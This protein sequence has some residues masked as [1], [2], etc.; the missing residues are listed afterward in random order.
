MV[1]NG[2]F[3]LTNP[4]KSIWNVEKYLEGTSINNICTV[5]IIREKID[6]SLMKRALNNIV[7]KNDAFR[8][9]IKLKDG[10][11]VQFFK[12]FEPFD[13]DVIHIKDES[14]LKD[15][16]KET[17]KYKFSVINSRLFYFKI[18]IFK[19]GQ[20][21]V[22][23]TV[24]HIISDSWSLGLVIKNILSE[25]H[26]V[27]ESIE[28]PTNY[29][30]I[31]YIKKE[32]EYKR[33]NRYQNDFDYWKKTFENIPEKAILPYD[34][35]G[36]KDKSYVAERKSFLI[37]KIEM[38]KIK[39]FCGKNKI[40]V[41][42]F[43][44]SVYAIYLGRVSGK[45]DFVIGTPILNRTSIKEKQTMGMFV[46]TTPIRVKIP[47]NKTTFTD[48][49]QNFSVKMITNL[50]HQRYSYMQILE[51]LHNENK[52]S[53]NLYSLL[54]S[55][56][57]TKAFDEKYGNYST[58]WVFNG[59][60]IDDCSIHLTDINN[61]GELEID[62][63]YLI[64]KYSEKEIEKT[65]NRILTII[66]Q[67]IKNPQIELLNIEI[68]TKEEKEKILYKF[69][70]KE[71]EFKNK[72]TLLEM[73]NNNVKKK[74]KEIAVVFEKQELTYKELDEK[75][76]SLADYLIKH[77]VKAEDVIS[78]VLK[79]S[80]DLIITIYA[81]IKTGA[82]YTLIDNS[83]PQ[84][85]INYIINDSKS[86]Y[87]I[88][89]N[90]K[91]II[92]CENIIN[93]KEIDI[94]RSTFVKPR[95]NPNLCIIYTSGSTGNPKGV[96]LEKAGFKNLLLAFDKEMNI[97]KYKNILGIATVSF[98]MFEVEL[99]SSLTFGNTLILANE[100][101]Q[102]NPIKMSKLIEKHNV[103]FLVT[104]PSRIELLLADNCKKALQI[105]KAFQLGGEKIT[106]NLYEKL[107]KETNAK[108]F[109]GYGPTEITACC[110]NK[111]IKEKDITIG[112]PIS[113]MQ[114]YICN[115][116]LMLQPT[117][118]LGEICIAGIGVSKGYINNKKL[119]E[120]KFV[121][122]PF[123]EG[124][125][126]KTGDLGLY[127]DNGDIEY[128]GRI[129]NQVKIRGLRIELE[130]IEDKINKIPHINSNVVL[131]MT[132]AQGHDYLCDYFTAD[133]EIETQ[134]IRNQLSQ[135]LPTYM[136]PRITIQI[137]KMP[138]TI[139]GK[140]DK[141]KLKGIK[142]DFKNKNIHSSRN[143]TDE[144]LL[145]NLKELL[146]NPDIGIDDSFFE[147][148]GDSLVA[149]NLIIRIQEQLNIQINVKDIDENPVI[150]DLSDF[151]AKEGTVAE[152]NKIIKVEKREYYRTSTAQKRIYF[153][154]K[155]AGEKNIIYNTPGGII[156]NGKL[157]SKKLEECI[158]IIIDRHESL[159]TYFEIENGEV[160]QKIIEKP[161]FKLKIVKKANYE[162]IPQIFKNFVSYFDLAKA[163][164]FKAMYIE[165]TNEKSA[166]FIDAHH[167]IIDGASLAILT[168]EICKIYN[169]EKLEQ[170]DY[171]YKDFT[172]YEAEKIASGKFEEAEKYW[173]EQ[174][175]GEIP[176]LNMPTTYSRPVN[177]SFEGKKVYS[178]IN[179]SLKEKI[180]RITKNTGITQY[181]LMLT[182][183]Y[184]LLSRYTAQEDIV[185][186][187]PIV[188]RDLPET[189][190][191]IGMFVN[192]LALRMKIDSENTV[193]E[194][195]MKVKEK[196][197][198][199]YE[200]QTYPFDELVNK[201]DLSRDAT[202]NPLISTMFTY[203]NN[204]Y[205]SLKFKDIE[206]KY[207]VPDINI[208]KFDLSLEVIPKKEELDISLEYATKLFEEKFITN[209]V[210]NYLSLLEE[211]SNNIDAKISKL[212]IVSAEEE[213]RLK[214]F[215]N[216]Y[217]EYPK[218]KSL[219]ELFEQ[220]VQKTPDN[221]AVEFEDEY[222][223][224][225]QLDEKATNL[226][227]NIKEKYNI[228][229]ND[230][231]GIMTSRSLEMIVAIIAVLKTGG[232][233]IPIDP[234]YP[235]DRIYYMLNSSKAK[236][237]L[238]Q[239]NLETKMEYRNKVYV[240]LKDNNLYQKPKEE[241]ELKSSPENLAYVIF[242]SGSTGN[243]KGV[244]LKQSNII[245]FINGMMKEFKFRVEDTIVSVTTIS[246]DI[247]VLE[248]LMPLLNGMKVIIANE[249]QQINGK[250][251]NELC[252]KKDVN[253]IQTTP[254]RLQIYL[255]DLE[256]YDFLENASHILIGGEPFPQNLLNELKKHTK[257][258][259]YNMYGPTET[260]VW[261]TMKDLS[262]TNK[263]TIGKPIINTQVYILD[264]NL[265]TQPI[266]VPGEI[267]IA[268]DG[269]SEGYLDNIEKT[270]ESFINNP[271]KNQTI[272]YKTGDIG[273][274]TQNGEIICFGRIDNQVKIR[275]LRIELEEIETV[276]QNHPSIIK[277]CVR[278]QTIDNR[279]FLIAYF[280][281]KKKV[282]NNEI[283]RYIS[284]YLPRYMVP[285]YY[286]P[287][288]KFPYTPNGKIDKKA[289][290]M[291]SEILQT[292]REKYV[293]PVTELEKK[294]VEIWEK[295]LNI[296]PIG[297]EDNFFELGGD[298]LLAMNLNLELL[299][300][301][302]QV[303]Y[304]D[305][306]RYPTIIEQEERINAITKELLF[307][308]IED[309]PDEH[310]NTL[311]NAK[312]NIKIEKYNPR[313]V[314]ITGATGFLGIHILR[315]FITNGNCN[316]YCI[317][318]DSQGI[319]AETR[320]YQKLHYYFGNKYDYLVGKRIIGVT[321]DASKP[322]FGLNEEK[323]KELLQKIDLVINSAA[324]VAH[325]GNYQKFYNTNVK[326]VKFITEFCKKG[327]IKLYHISTM[328][329]MGFNLDFSYMKVNNR[330]W[331]LK[332]KN[333]VIFDESKLYIGQLI[334][335]V[336]ARSKFEAE[337]HVLNEINNGL[338]AYILRMG[339]L[340]PRFSDGVF[341]ENFEE[342]DL[343]SKLST[344]IKLGIIPRYLLDH[345]IELTPVDY[346]AK[347]IY[348][349]TTNCNGT[350]RI[351]HLYNHNTISVRKLV[352]F[353]NQMNKNIKV[354][355]EKEFK[356]KIKELIN[357]KESKYSLKKLI[358][359]FDNN[360]HLKYNND[361]ITTS[362]FTKK[363]LSRIGFKWCKLSKSY[364]KKMLELLE[365]GFE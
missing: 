43:F 170:L 91:D 115:E 233:Y 312:Q 70:K 79:R 54:I 293:A 28:L 269:V 143:K 283:R 321:G 27:K 132:D 193:R 273:K 72:E 155:K 226:A 240:D 57:V 46:N 265:N 64:E 345:H 125:L 224:Y 187:S 262:D 15:V 63:D 127:R 100:E 164:I 169:D 20:G 204:G 298:S 81:I 211:I 309:L 47:Q 363:Y 150:K 16:E 260:A 180:E 347:A 185:I 67:I 212:K 159:R 319:K 350:N 191:L 76:N 8:I 279:E 107:R 207:Y 362:K 189:S 2:C 85:R 104:T 220:Q 103:E 341:Q 217:E 178:T 156:I 75:S 292:N 244:M 66:E 324:N 222:L 306:F 274:Y 80:L 163:P 219:A 280:K 248:S 360:L 227:K 245:N 365:E 77:G 305:I 327:K 137:E 317:I 294:L 201:L 215:N 199:A 349:L 304:Q 59:Y 106:E 236:L 247:F 130:E 208:S 300:L 218:N 102:K 88:V 267:Y 223:T 237:L 278:K 90:P 230:L 302:G 331:F 95:K 29:S 177:Q 136:I 209:L 336:Y 308:K 23:L 253:I 259:I 176:V 364:L 83:F 56:Q 313:N 147:I 42:N 342:N 3:E 289:L 333:K 297:I 241:I 202:R 314:L 234:N 160:V 272:M 158:K 250:A 34:K 10:K 38:E 310:I 36:N 61:T 357:D 229:P 44:M 1:E 142:V 168:E 344:F 126:Y 98:D 121:K 318:R 271:F 97:S 307:K 214:K 340:M 94:K 133:K 154:S 181:M 78:V 86:K 109:N 172:E 31:D 263:I 195:T 303:S 105:L 210:K 22:F 5:G 173:L 93:I 87:C 356:E 116:D 26:A 129:D 348:K 58:K 6:E 275:G 140:I 257:G 287:L 13:I 19:N 188:G 246:F 353:A 232:A 117:G 53:G 37:N 111:L 251:F 112:T 118:I 60:N 96:L 258:R 322:N 254:S 167:I 194:L 14:E 62:Y 45:D 261:S 157:D 328:S 266:G 235:S 213:K 337:S 335:N 82:T 268:G 277:A 242:T 151:I 256:N 249:E 359:D 352:N 175:R 281:A 295:V 270:K 119:T 290:P 288:E 25:Y 325:Y 120:E 299:E 354:L 35:K 238:I 68:V 197:L 332:K 12:E 216:T 291:P 296:Q 135:I 182:A 122:N 351:F 264:K 221:I 276:I 92:K 71:E 149:I 315:E 4:Q 153:A 183:Y 206:T 69:N 326:S 284:N 346:S 343:I 49:A 124:R 134:E 338:D 311:E 358:N 196:L 11:P 84:S 334:E 32:A 339:Y 50:K 21:A 323:A 231:I 171:T 7:K 179:N 145:Q 24:N 148:G 165:F 55:Y 174:F 205:K 239:K 320:L 65:H 41:F 203:Q 48:Y 33:S 138:H 146:D 228:K 17:A 186:G 301:S 9:T 18:V 286:V 144:I 114:A 40:S 152:K 198:E 101:E 200:Y 39:D 89:D 192:T 131:K 161:E 123:G 225:K 52:E 282:T 73:F 316:I 99:L 184:L 330:R 108:I 128:A 329:V 110:T 243:P 30:Y 355:N 190:N 361:I 285:S 74:P 141:K 166:L 252:I 51:D 113:N 139:N 255:N 162:E